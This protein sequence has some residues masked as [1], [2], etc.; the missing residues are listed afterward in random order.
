MVFL[1]KDTEIGDLTEVTK[2][3]SGKRVLPQGGGG[4]GGIEYGPGQIGP[5]NSRLEELIRAKNIGRRGSHLLSLRAKTRVR[6]RYKFRE[7]CR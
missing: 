5:V 1:K 2:I 6:N 3:A 7:S 4:K